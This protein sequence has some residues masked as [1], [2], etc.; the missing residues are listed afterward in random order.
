MDD[1]PAVR[2]HLR[3]VHAIALMNLGEVCSGLA[4]LAALDADQR[5]IVTD[6]RMRYEQKARGPITAKSDF[7][8][9]SPG[10][11]GPFVA[12]AELFDQDGLRVAVA[13]AEWTLGRREPRP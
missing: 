8:P 9:P 1:R 4:V 7:T 12:R 3:S 13:T 11:E 10:H 6:L 2:N 5:G